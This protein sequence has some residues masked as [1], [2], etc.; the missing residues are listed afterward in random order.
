MR[1]VL[2][3][4]HKWHQPNLL[5]RKK[6]LACPV[7]LFQTTDRASAVFLF[8]PSIPIQLIHTI[9]IIIVPTNRVHSHNWC[10]LA[11]CCGSALR[12]NYYIHL[13]LQLYVE[14]T[15]ALL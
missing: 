10:Y 8:P 15:V 13:A 1:F 11:I 14:L 7:V 5:K 12:Y 9:I 4:N 2:L 6:N 3:R